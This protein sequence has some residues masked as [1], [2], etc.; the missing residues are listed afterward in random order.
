MNVWFQG[1]KTGSCTNNEYLELKI[2]AKYAEH[3][4]DES[5]HSF[6][7]SQLYIE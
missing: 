2:N 5:E 7:L 3:G 1:V 4:R 6:S